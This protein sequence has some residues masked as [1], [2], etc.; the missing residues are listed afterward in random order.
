MAKALARTIKTR[1]DYQGA[2]SA[3][4][5]LRGNGSGETDAERRLQ[6][7]LQEI[8]KFDSDEEIEEDGD[9]ADDVG[10]LRRRWSDEE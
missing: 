3:A 2:K 10:G 4:H 1:R 9:F 8:E 5:R 7:L 6:A